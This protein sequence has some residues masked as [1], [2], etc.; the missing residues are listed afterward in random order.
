MIHFSVIFEARRIVP[1]HSLTVKAPWKGTRLDSERM[2]WPYSPVLK[3]AR[4]MLR[5]SG[6]DV[7]RQPMASGWRYCAPG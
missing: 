5:G 3:N 2:I 7:A 1:D 4:K 6:P